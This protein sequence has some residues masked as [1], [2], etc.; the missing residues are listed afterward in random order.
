MRHRV[1][2]KRDRKV[3]TRTAKLT[4]KKNIVTTAHRGGIG[5]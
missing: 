3:F 2:K 1:N 4:H 5:L